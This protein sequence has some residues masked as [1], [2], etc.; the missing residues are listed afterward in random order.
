MNVKLSTELEWLKPYLKR[1]KNIIPV[2]KLEKIISGKPREEQIQHSH[3]QLVTEYNPNT[4]HTKR[5]YITLNL[6]YMKSRK[7]KPT[8]RSK[9]P[10]SKIDLLETLAH[11]LAHLKEYKHT[12]QHKK[13]ENRLCTIFMN[14]LE[15]TGYVSEEHEFKTQKPKF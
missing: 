11:E 13:L 8:L 12:P 5:R 7:L 14:M 10:F 6:Y 15:K 9:E 3:A 1:V 4:G 2:H